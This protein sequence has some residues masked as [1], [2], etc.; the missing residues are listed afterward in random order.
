MVMA[1]S[2]IASVAAMTMPASTSDRANDSVR[3]LTR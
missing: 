3:K 2:Q 1:A